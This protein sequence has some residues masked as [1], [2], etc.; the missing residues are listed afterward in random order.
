MDML[1]N[2]F[3]NALAAILPSTASQATA[4]APPPIQSSGAGD[5]A[6]A[7]QKKREGQQ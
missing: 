6:I 5:A 3:T 1:T 4:P 2:A 7:A